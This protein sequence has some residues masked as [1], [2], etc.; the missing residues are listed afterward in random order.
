VPAQGHADPRLLDGCHPRDAGPV[1]RGHGQQSQQVPR[2]LSAVTADLAVEKLLKKNPH[3][4]RAENRPVDS[5]SWED[6]RNSADVSARRMAGPTACRPRLN[7]STPAA[8]A[9]RRPTNPE[10][11]LSTD[12]ANFGN[13]RRQT[14]PVGRFPS[15]AW[16]LYDMHGNVG[17]GAP[18]PTA[19]H[20][21]A[22]RQ[23]RWKPKGPTTS[24]A[25]LLGVSAVL[26]RAAFRFRA[27][28]V[29]RNA[30]LGVRVCFWRE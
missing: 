22:T 28:P 6:G 27:A 10:S 16:G 25:G 12:Q 9:R 19:L 13:M 24:C 23:I 8:A 26:C 20:R 14:T 21:A 4:L 17:S 29:V 3:L 18:T 5:V 7:G 30:F 1:A 15:N 11:S 2:R